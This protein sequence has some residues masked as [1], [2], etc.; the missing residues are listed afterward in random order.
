MLLR[1]GTLSAG[2]TGEACLCLG[3][4]SRVS[5][6]WRCRIE[7]IIAPLFGDQLIV[8]AALNDPALFQNHDAVGILDGG[9]PVGDNE[10]GSPG[11]QSIHALLDQCLGAGVDGAGGLIQNQHRRVGH[12]RPGDGQQLPLALAQVGAVAV[13]MVL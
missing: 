7:L 6:R 8:A 11:H 2:K 10:R 13:S 3:T 5:L 1:R 9:K 4:R 12:R